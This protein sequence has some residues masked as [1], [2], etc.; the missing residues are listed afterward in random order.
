[1]VWFRPLAS[2]INLSSLLLLA[3]LA[4]DRLPTGRWSSL[5]AA[6]SGR[7]LAKAEPETDSAPLDL[8]EMP[9]T[10]APSGLPRPLQVHLQAAKGEEDPPLSLDVEENPDPIL[11]QGL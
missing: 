10:G 7:S 5:T 4:D 8:K 2:V 1:M 11:D 6:D 9:F 3:P